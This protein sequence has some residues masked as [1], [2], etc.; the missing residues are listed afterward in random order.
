MMKKLSTMRVTTSIYWLSY[1][2]FFKEA[3][4][5]YQILDFEWDLLRLNLIWI[6]GAL[7][8]FCL[9]LFKFQKLKQSKNT[10]K[11]FCIDFI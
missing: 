1:K 8:K 11:S 4:H 3:F 6:Y 7:N 9:L 10:I 5:E 2:R